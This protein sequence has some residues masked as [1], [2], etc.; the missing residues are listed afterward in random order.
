MPRTKKDPDLV[1]VEDGNA[2]VDVMAQFP[3]LDTFFDRNPRD[4]TDADLMQLINRERAQRALFIE[5]KGA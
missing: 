3:T 4:L 1:A 2:A 5:K